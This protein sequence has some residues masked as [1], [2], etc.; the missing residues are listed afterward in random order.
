[1]SKLKSVMYKFTPLN[2][3]F[4]SYFEYCFRKNDLTPLKIPISPCSSKTVRAMEKVTLSAIYRKAGRKLLPLIIP[5]K[6]EK[7]H[8]IWTLY[9]EKCTSL[10]V[11]FFTLAEASPWSCTPKY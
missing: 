6:H 2:R 9:K 5:E 7:Y 10:R 8:Q 4:C 1:M 11:Y 3:N